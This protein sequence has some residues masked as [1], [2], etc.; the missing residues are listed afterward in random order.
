MTCKQPEEEQ[1]VVTGNAELVGEGVNDCE[2]DWPDTNPTTE[3]YVTT[4][5]AHDEV[6]AICDTKAVSRN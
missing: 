4:K 3:R 2:D 1:T 6:S 5:H